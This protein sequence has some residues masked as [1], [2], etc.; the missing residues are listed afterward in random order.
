MTAVESLKARY[1]EIQQRIAAAAAASGRAAKDILLVGISK[2]SGVEEIRELVLMG[3]RDFGENQMQQLIQRS[4][5]IDEWLARYRSLAVAT[6][7]RP[8]VDPVRWHMVG[9]LQ[10]NKA[11]KAA[12]ICRLIHS[13]DNLG[14]AEDLQDIAVAKETTIEVL[15]Q[16]NT[17]GDRA[18]SG[19]AIP[20]AI[21]LVESIESMT[22]VKV[23]GLMAMASHEPDGEEPRATFARTRELFQEIVTAG[24]VGPD[25]N[26]L[27]MGMSN[28]F[29]D[30]IAE[31]SNVV[32]IGSALFGEP[33]A[34][35]AAPATDPAQ[36]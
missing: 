34:D 5:M 14:L 20:A 23:R 31:G 6:G 32:R 15:V 8:T 36:G 7:K 2:Y 29:E 13:V 35:Q 24:V 1:T 4:A 22:Q 10:R 11:R 25:F 21:H 18:K 19:C 12:D 33:P 26:L 9:H 30:A 28:D 17:C 27:S 3:H 16:V